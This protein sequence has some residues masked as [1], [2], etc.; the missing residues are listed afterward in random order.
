MRIKPPSKEQVLLYRAQHQ[1]GVMTAKRELF[2]VAAKDAIR[3]AVT[4]EDLKEVFIEM[5]E[6][7][8]DD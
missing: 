5:L 6:L 4:L 1:C 7:G 8:R 2:L 3:D